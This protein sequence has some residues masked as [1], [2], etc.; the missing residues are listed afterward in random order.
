MY[1][2]NYSIRGNF[3]AELFFCDDC[4]FNKNWKKLE[5]EN[6]SKHCVEQ[7]ID[8]PRQ[9]ADQ[10]CT[11][12]IASDKDECTTFSSIFCMSHPLSAS[13]HINSGLVK[14]IPI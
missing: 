11:K 6:N 5:K 12:E 9:R 1:A 13:V 7:M 14:S 3:Q 10:K 4:I 8:I 2:S